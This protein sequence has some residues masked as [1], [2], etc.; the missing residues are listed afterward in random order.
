MNWVSQIETPSGMKAPGRPL[1]RD[2]FNGGPADYGGTIQLA[3]GV[4][5]SQCRCKAEI[6]SSDVTSHILTKDLTRCA[7]AI[8]MASTSMGSG[9][10][11]TMKRIRTGS[12]LAVLRLGFGTANPNAFTAYFLPKYACLPC[13]LSAIKARKQ[14]LLTFF[15]R[16]PRA[17]SQMSSGPITGRS[18]FR[19][20]TWPIMH[21]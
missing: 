11:G 20:S 6:F 17:S 18:S 16:E 8:I 21:F 7:L 2:Q 15:S 13:H 3:E 10:H 1:R 12:F 14:T 4:G 5:S 19:F 9:S